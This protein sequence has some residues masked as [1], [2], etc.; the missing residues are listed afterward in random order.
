[1]G[2]SSTGCDK[3][4][5]STGIGGDAAGAGSGSGWTGSGTARGGMIE[6]PRSQSAG[7]SSSELRGAR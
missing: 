7:S 5:G 3:T 6:A 1:M 2:S 4:G